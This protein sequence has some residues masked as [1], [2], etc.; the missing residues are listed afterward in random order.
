M[1]FSVSEQHGFLDATKPT[2]LELAALRCALDGSETWRRILRD[3][4]DSLRVTDRDFNSAGGLTS[5]VLESSVPR[6]DTPSDIRLKPPA[7]IVDHSSLPHTGDFIVWIADGAITA[8]EATAHG[9]GVW[10][11]DADVH[12][13]SFRSER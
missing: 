3:Q 13:F 2:A 8:L 9:D 4:V 5:F 11:I 12:E 6:A 7:C 1:E 10:P